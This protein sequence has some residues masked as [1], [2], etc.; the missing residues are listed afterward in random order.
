MFDSCTGL[1]LEN[2]ESVSGGGTMIHTPHLAGLSHYFSRR[3]NSKAG[4]LAFVLL[5]QLIAAGIACGQATTSLRGTVTDSSGGDFSAVSA[6]LADA[7]AKNVRQAEI[8]D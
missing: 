3:G 5:A 7:D 2:R 8:G 6:A 4:A 1:H